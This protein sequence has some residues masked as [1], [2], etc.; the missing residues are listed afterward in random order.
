[1]TTKFK[2]TGKMLGIIA[3]LLFLTTQCTKFSE[4]DF[5]TPN[6]FNLDA[7][8]HTFE[9]RMSQHPRPES[10]RMI[11]IIGT[12][13]IN[14]YREYLHRIGNLYGADIRQD[15]IVYF[16][17]FFV[18]CEFYRGRFYNRWRL[19][20]IRGEWFSI[21]QTDDNRSMQ[22]TIAE[23][24]E[25]VERTIFMHLHYYRYQGRVTIRQRGR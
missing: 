1:M 15:T 2:K 10:F 5:Q 20:E 24:N 18:I 16:E 11:D 21:K 23:N 9:I 7:S 8:S 6:H 4:I 3:G 22:V 13:R 25:G 14:G 19:A 17:N 12:L